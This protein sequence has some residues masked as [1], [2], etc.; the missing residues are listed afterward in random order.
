MLMDTGVTCWEYMGIDMGGRLMTACYFYKLFC[1][2]M[3]CLLDVTEFWNPRSLEEPI[4]S[5]MRV[6]TESCKST[7][8]SDSFIAI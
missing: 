4:D 3:D 7:T 8:D 1:L 5:Y 6:T 2:T